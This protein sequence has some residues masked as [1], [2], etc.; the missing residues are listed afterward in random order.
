MRIES[1]EFCDHET[2]WHLSEARFDG[3]NL[4]VGISGV[5]KSKVLRALD[6]VRR[7]GLGE[8]REAGDRSWRLVCEHGGQRFE[9]SGHMTRVGG[10]R[11]IDEERLQVDAQPLIARVGGAITFKSMPV[12]RLNRRE[13]VL[14]LFA[15]E[16]EVAALRT[17]LGCIL[18][19]P[20]GRVEPFVVSAAKLRRL[21]AEHPIRHRISHTIEV[22]RGARRLDD[23]VGQRLV[24][25][26]HTAQKGLPGFFGELKS[27]FSDIFPTVDDIR[28]VEVP[29]GSQVRL[30]LQ[31]HEAGPDV[32]VGHE[33]ISQGMLRT[34]DALR[35]LLM[36]SPGSVWLVDEFE[37]SLGVNCLHA[38]TR[39]IDTRADC[40]FILTSHHPYVIQ[41]IPI[42]AWKLVRRRGSTVEL[43][44]A[45]DVPSLAGE[46]HLDAFTR[47]IN[48]PEYEDGID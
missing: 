48:A 46:S 33:D 39:L 24:T 9:W 21:D 3:L 38:V 11:A 43:I 8:A 20:E 42:D 6:G 19:M 12:P 2:G 17:G 35:T 16:D 5:G 45:R 27:T 47:L 34:L 41:S 1:F 4:L 18:Q 25:F 10:E 26:L 15:D 7:L 44:A 31:I 30:E 32:W 14:S 36:M 28:V 40:Q 22:L 29:L 23:M 37:N 13:S